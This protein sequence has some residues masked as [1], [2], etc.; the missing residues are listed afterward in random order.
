MGLPNLKSRLHDVDRCFQSDRVTI[1]DVV[2]PERLQDKIDRVNEVEETLARMQECASAADVFRTFSVDAAKAKVME[3]FYGKTSQSRQRAAETILEMGIGKPV[4][5][6]ASLSLRVSDM[7][8]EELNGEIE[9]LMRE[10]G[11]ASG[12]GKATRL[13]I[14]PKGK[15]GPISTQED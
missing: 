15:P 9:S 8:E 12:E 4:Q 2:R 1:E 10:L 13:L 14:G 5:R 11:F 7:K 3:M 6:I